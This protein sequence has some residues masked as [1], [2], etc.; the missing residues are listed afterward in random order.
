MQ[1][2]GQPGLGDSQ[3]MQRADFGAK[4]SSGVRKLGSGGHQIGLAGI[5]QELAL[6][7][8]IA[9]VDLLIVNVRIGLTEEELPVQV[10]PRKRIRGQ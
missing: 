8:Q 3:T 9:G 6:Q 10:Q 4:A 5:E 7:H 2:V 1:A